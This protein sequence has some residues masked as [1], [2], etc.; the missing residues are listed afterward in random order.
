MKYSRPGKFLAV[1]V[2]KFPPE[3]RL[4]LKRERE[5]GKRGKRERKG[6]P[7]SAFLI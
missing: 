2:D 1:E 3:G 6:S 7:W 5:K 4:R